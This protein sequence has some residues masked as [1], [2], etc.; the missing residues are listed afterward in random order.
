MEANGADN[1]AVH[2]VMY[3][4]AHIQIQAPASAGP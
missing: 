4:F 1:E 3:R 2:W